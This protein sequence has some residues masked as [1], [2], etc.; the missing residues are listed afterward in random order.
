MKKIIFTIIC[1][2]LF[3]PYVF[4]FNIKDIKMDIF[5]DNDGK[6]YV[7]ET[8]IA[9]VTDGTEG[10]KQIYNLGQSSI[11]NFNVKM[12]NKNF[13]Y[14]NNWDINASF[15]SKKYKCGINTVSKG[16][17]LCFGI[18]EYGTNTYELS[19]EISNFV[20]GATDGDIIYWELIPKELGDKPENFYVKVYSDFKY[21]DT[22]EVWGYGYLNGYAYIYDG[23][24]EMTSDNALKDNEYVVLLARFPKGTFNTSVNYNNDS[25]YYVDMASEGSFSSQTSFWDKLMNIIF[26]I[27][28]FGIVFVPFIIAII[29]TNNNRG[30]KIKVHFNKEDKKLGKEVLPFHSIPCSNNIYKAYFVAANYNLYKKQTDFLG[31]VLLKWL[32]DGVVETIKSAD[33]KEDVSIKFNGIDDYKCLDIEKKLYNYMEQASV[34]GILEKNEF[35]NWCSSNYNTILNWFSD[36]IDAEVL[37]L[38]KEGYID[39]LEYKPNK[40]RYVA[41]PK[42]KEE[43]IKLKGLKLFFREFTL[44]DEKEA[45]EVKVWKDYL[46][47]AQILGMASTVAKQFKKLYPDVIP[48]DYMNDFIFIYAISNDGLK[49]ASA[50]KSRA[51]NYSSGG[52]GSSFGGGGGGSF[53]GGGGGFR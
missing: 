46:I 9:N 43:A 52:G 34:D 14:L 8:W 29:F 13:T 10:Y 37:E 27:F 4:A 44:I 40:F 39:K 24:I 22:D 47:F 32:K 38:V 28:S 26:F 15:E 50:A 6:A 33:K 17:E 51:E 19:Y 41:E 45:I 21:S 16:V 5:I 30:G 18:S 2:F 36:A 1:L 11:S 53:G 31:A 42:V 12:N 25:Q 35:K 23:Y 20:I 7:K 3:M 48:D 49:S